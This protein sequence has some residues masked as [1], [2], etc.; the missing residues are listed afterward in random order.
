MNFG[1]VYITLMLVRSSMVKI[2]LN[3]IH[4]R[5]HNNPAPFIKVSW[6]IILVFGKPS[7]YWVYHIGTVS[8]HIWIQFCFSFRKV[9]L[10]DSVCGRP[11]C[12]LLWP[13]NRKQWVEV[14]LHWCMS[15]V[16]IQEAN[17]G[18]GCQPFRCNRQHK[19]KQ[20]KILTAHII[21]LGFF[22][23]WSSVKHWK[24]LSVQHISLLCTCEAASVITPSPG[25][26]PVISSVIRV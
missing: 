3:P 17:S 5:L 23:F 4:C 9:L 7:F 16:S 2:P 26:C 22:F 15:R 19:Q 14:L 24:T 11:V 6:S 10:D 8:A 25:L 13:H 21:L 20:Y 18:G 1:H 12:W